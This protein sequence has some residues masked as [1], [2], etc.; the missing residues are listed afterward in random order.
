MNRSN[1][2][3][4]A[5]LL[6]L[7]HA[8]GPAA[9]TE[10]AVD[11]SSDVQLY[12]VP[13][14][15]GT[16]EMRQ[17]RY[18]QTLG[19][20]VRDILG[21]RESG[22]PW[23]AFSSRLR[24]DSDLGQSA[25]LSDPTNE[26]DYIPGVEAAPVDL[27]YAYFDARQLGGNALAVRFGRQYVVDP[28]GWWSFDGARVSIA[29]PAPVEIAGYAGFEQRAVVPLLATSRFTADGV[30][31][32]SR[33]DLEANRWPSYLDQRKLAPAVG[34]SVASHGL[35]WLDAELAYRR[36]EERDAAYL[37]VFPESP[38]SFEVIE[39]S[40]VATERLGGAIVVSRDQLGAIT[41]RVVYD[42][43]LGIVNE[44]A[45]TL[46]WFVTEP[47]TLTAGYDYTLPTYDGD[48]IFNW[49]STNPMTSVELGA[50]LA[51]SRNLSLAPRAGARA[52]RVSKG[53]SA[54]E[55]PEAG[56]TNGQDSAPNSTDAFASFAVVRR[57]ERGKVSLDGGGDGSREGHQI[58]IDLEIDH[59]FRE[60]DYDALLLLSLHDWHDEWL[61][62]RDATSFT[63][64]VGG[65]MRPAAHS[66][67]GVE[68]EHTTNRLVGQRYRIL[69]TLELEVA[70]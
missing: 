52:Y 55:D 46:S 23:L 25:S 69:F 53:A 21:K 26:E 33:R 14:P 31:R 32:G 39:Q 61:P 59:T 17:R 10:A 7:G 9:A 27:Q 62:A 3:I 4:A 28:L 6:A 66:R 48:S 16:R 47:I 45:A 42:C 58:G 19:L 20:T 57:W 8:P 54:E 15:Y 64:V 65:G 22:G 1:W 56:G 41:G 63:Y 37:T 30:H 18:T 24:L 29:A 68:W 67:L 13:N 34:F 12:A 36:V 44:H 38:G 40:R 11:A 2:Y 50:D 5:T 35:D 60:G 70:L 43:L 51:P 49:F